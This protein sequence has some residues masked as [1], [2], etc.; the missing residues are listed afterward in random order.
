MGIRGLRTS[1]GRAL[2]RSCAR[3]GLTRGAPRVQV[4]Q[5]AMPPGVFKLLT[6]VLRTANNILGGISFVTL[7]KITGVQ[8]SAGDDKKSAQ[9]GD[10]ARA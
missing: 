7:A 1:H 5:P 3:P 4:A 10:A 8:S 9:V 2:G 6:S